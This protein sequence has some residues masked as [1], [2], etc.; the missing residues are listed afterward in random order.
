MLN[1]VN[2]MKALV[3]VPEGALLFVSYVAGREPTDRAVREAERSRREGIA[4]RHFVGKLASQRVTKKG[5]YVFTVLC[6]NRD[7]ER[8]GTRDGYR[9]FNPSLGNLLTVEVVQ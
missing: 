3:G 2:A 7:D 9:T 4:R 1:E 6:D 8:R 5:E